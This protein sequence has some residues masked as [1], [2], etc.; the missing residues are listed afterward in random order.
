[1]RRKPVIIL[2]AGNDHINRPIPSGQ[3]PLARLETKR[4]QLLNIRFRHFSPLG[5]F[6]HEVKG[7]GVADGIQVIPQRLAANRHTLFN[8]D[9]RFRLRER[10]AFQCVGR[11][12]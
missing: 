7:A 3:F 8:D 1:M 6:P 10:A 12:R 9:L 2:R 4:V 11:V 5:Q